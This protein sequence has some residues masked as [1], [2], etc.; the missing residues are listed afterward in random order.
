MY[1]WITVSLLR[2]RAAKKVSWR[3]VGADERERNMD[4]QA[5][6]P[7]EWASCRFR[8]ALC[9]SKGARSSYLFIYTYFF[10][11]ESPK[12]RVFIFCLS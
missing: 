4:G 5:D 9:C 3:N 12:V 10:L 7:A 2:E 6:R 11:T 1:S 8:G